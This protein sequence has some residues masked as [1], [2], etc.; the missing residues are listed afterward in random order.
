MAEIVYCEYVA[1]CETKDCENSGIAI[2]VPADCTQPNISCA[3]CSQVITNL[4]KIEPV[5]NDKKK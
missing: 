4:V 5:V 3:A 1:T 2:T